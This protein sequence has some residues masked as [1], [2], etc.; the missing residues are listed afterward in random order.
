MAKGFDG[1]RRADLLA[2]SAF[3]ALLGGLAAIT[4]AV[5]Y[6]LVSQGLTPRLGW[7]WGALKCTRTYARWIFFTMLMILA[8][9]GTAAAISLSHRAMASRRLVS[10]LLD[11]RIPAPP[12]VLQIA[13]RLRVESA[14]DVVD[15]GTPVAFTYGWIRPRVLISTGLVAGLTEDEMAAVLAHER[16][17]LR[18][19]DPLRVLLARAARDGLFYLPAAGELYRWFEAAKEVAA[20]AAVIAELGRV[21]LAKALCKL[22]AWRQPETP[23]AIAGAMGVL[24]LRVGQLLDPDRF[25]PRPG[26]SARSVALASLLVGF[27]LAGFFGRCR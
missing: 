20:D 12:G 1:A 19:R 26:I 21:E 22:A 3:W 10:C 9:T 17:H 13:R 15:E 27:L 8:F 11:R 23:F 7:C 16:Y 2:R 6:G 14:L 18:R 5:L 4:A 25:A 24:Q